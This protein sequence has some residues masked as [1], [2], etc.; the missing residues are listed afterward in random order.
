MRVEV[1]QRIIACA[2]VCCLA[3]ISY[4]SL[5]AFAGEPSQSVKQVVT[6]AVAVNT[7][8][9]SQFDIPQSVQALGSLEAVQKVNI[10]TE[11]SGRIT[12]IN[13]KDG[14]TAVKG[15]PIVQLDNVKALADYQSAVTASNVTQTKYRRSKVLLNEAVSQ[16]E[17]DQLQADVESKKA[18]VQKAQSVLNNKK[19]LAPFNGVLGTFKVQVGDY[20]SAGASIVTIV[21]TDQLR[22]DYSIPERRLPELKI[23]QLVKVTVSAYP[24]KMFYGTVSY[25]S[26]SINPDTRAV[27]VQAMINNS[28]HLLSPGMFVHV[29]QQ[30]SVT[31]DALVVPAEA[32]QADIKGYY[33]YL[34][35]NGHVAQTS[36]TIGQRKGDFVQILNGLKLGDT[37]VTAGQLNLSDGSLIRVVS[38][39]K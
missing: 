25:I 24:N 39:Q 28:K 3:G 2:L 34:V 12:A 7:A 18:D 8:Q 11:D 1:K 22:V 26:P 13:F 23:G 14:Q 36:V 35:R 4:S 30:V 21:N 20:V 27:P 37:V 16:Q 19:V 6:D 38:Q 32:V 33:V 10:S 17:L 5:I 31:K 9:V 15:M 29:D